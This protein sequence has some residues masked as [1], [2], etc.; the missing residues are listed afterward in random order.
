VQHLDSVHCH[1]EVVDQSSVGSGLSHDLHA[2]L[3]GA[4]GDGGGVLLHGKYVPAAG[5]LHVECV[6][7]GEVGDASS[8]EHCARLASCGQ[9]CAD[10]LSA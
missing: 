10:F 4:P 7:R 3:A 8:P 6:H 1:F 9:D 2:G 5:K